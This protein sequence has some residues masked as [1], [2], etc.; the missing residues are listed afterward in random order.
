MSTDLSDDGTFIEI[1][2]A[3]EIAS[4]GRTGTADTDGLSP[5][6]DRGLRASLSEAAGRLGGTVQSEI[7][8]ETER[9]A[10]A[11][12]PTEVVRSSDGGDDIL[13]RQAH[14]PDELPILLE[15]DEAGLM[16]WH[17]PEPAPKN[18]H[19]SAGT[20]VF[21]LRGTHTEVDDLAQQT[22][23]R[24]VLGKIGR[25]LVEVIVV[26][27][28]RGAVGSAL[29][30]GIKT[31]ET[32][33]RPHG[34]RTYRPDDMTEAGEPVP[35]ADAFASWGG[36]HGLLLIH[37]TFN[38]TPDSF[39]SMGPSFLGQLSEHYGG[40]VLAFDHP[41]VSVSPE[42]NAEWLAGALASVKPSM[43][44]VA[45]SRGG[46]VARLLDAS[47]AIELRHLVFSATPNNG[48]PLADTDH[49]G[50]LIDAVTNAMGLIPDNPITDSA[51]VI[52]TVLRHLAAG[53]VDAL[54]GLIAM[55]PGHEVLEALNQN[56]LPAGARFLTS[57]YEPSMSVAAWA[58]D[59][60]MDVVF[61]G[62]PNDLVVP[63]SSV[64]GPWADS[65]PTGRA[66]RFGP[67]DSVTHGGF[68]GHADVQG[69]LLD[70]L[71]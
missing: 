67:N 22:G 40:R 48:T 37:G 25:K 15:V 49:V 53:T 52:I 59:T 71:C 8:V 19:R 4:P 29:A 34:V 12:D 33:N 70:W 63:T 7:V 13:V 43:D 21:R 17:L 9:V 60:L 42:E 44:I 62:E 27:A 3:I 16:S 58:K 26:P 35:P 1:D 50:K 65:I 54:D 66:I 56:P 47:D 32:N 14:R 18:E 10:S 61:K 68:V 28:V 30:A 64:L 24:G 51:E 38:R 41:T 2:P 23:H 31:W 57:N 39:G 36:Q 55:R 6:E 69:Q 20:S 46:L 11:A 45:T 5:N